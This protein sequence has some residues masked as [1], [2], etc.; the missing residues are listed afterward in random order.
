MC[1]LILLERIENVGQ[2]GDVVRVKPGYARNYL[3]PQNK[4]VR[5]TEENRKCSRSSARSSRRPQP[6]A[7]DGS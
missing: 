5:A 2:M 7:A 1:R 6:A 4:A 3:L